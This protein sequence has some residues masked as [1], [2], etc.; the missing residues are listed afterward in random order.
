MS[1][2]FH[3]SREAARI[4]GVHPNSLRKWAD[5]GEINCIRT[6]SGQR[7]YDVD[8]YIGK[9]TTSTTICYC[10]VSSHK[11]RD[12]L[13]RQVEFLRNQYPTAEFVRDIGSGLNFK[14]KGL[15]TI[16]ER[17]MSG[18]H[19]TLVVAHRDRL[20]RFGIDLIRQFIEQNG[21]KLVVLDETLLSPKQE[22]INNLLNIVHVFSARMHR[23]GNYKKQI[24]QIVTDNGTEEVVPSLAQCK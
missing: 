12:D 10:R 1:T 2:K 20:A 13:E 18:T 16:L 19:I 3:P 22:L 21:G 6:K 15:K 7:R 17:A 11:Q 4:L 14:R 24:H 23:R 8:S 9:S 5:N